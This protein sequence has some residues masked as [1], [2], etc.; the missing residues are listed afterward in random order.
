MGPFMVIFF[1]MSLVTVPE[2]A[3][4]MRGSPRHLPLFCLL[5]SG[6]LSLLALA[7]GA[8]LLVALPRGLGQWLLGVALAPQPTRWCSRSRSPSWAGASSRAPVRACMPW[9]PRGAA[10]AR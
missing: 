5:V 6:G 1:G 3:R 4:I 8:L 2:A 7:W 10:C 9:E